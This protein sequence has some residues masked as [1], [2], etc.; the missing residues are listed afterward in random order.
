MSYVT[1]GRARIFVPEGKVMKKDEAFYNPAMR[2]QRDVTI[3]ALRVFSEMKGG[4]LSV[5]D[6][7]AGTG[8]RG[9]R[10]ALEVPGISGI[11]M[12]DM[13]PAA[14]RVL[15][16]NVDAVGLKVAKVE[17]KNCD[18][19][20]LLSSCDRTF[21]F[22]DIDPFGSPA[23]FLH[24]A[25]RALRHGSMLACTATDTGAL[26]GSF[27]KVCL[28]RY[29]V[30][31][32]KTDFYKET[33]VRVLTTAIM[34]EL[35]RRDLTFEPVYAHA[36]HYFR[37]IG[38]V[39]R[40]KSALTESFRKVKLISWCPRCIFRS[41]EVHGACPECGGRV[42]MLGPIWTGRLSDKDFCA[43]MAGE[44]KALGYRNTRELEAAAA[45]IEAPFYYDLH[46]LSK[47]ARKTPR[48]ADDVVSGLRAAGREA[49]RTRFCGTGVLTDASLSELL[50]LL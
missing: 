5:C 27:P 49:S 30:R 3:A 22:L 18:A 42:E 16:K 29:A 44:M 38:L 32:V 14:F 11:L 13:S 41:A 47:I 21:D 6:P 26:C 1:E 10:I 8:I 34:V 25:S 28:Q 23:G 4:G 35:A 33:G 45:E 24:A 46:R 36:N 7:L 43:K 40:K 17:M 19:D 48:K 39:R 9:I 37:V 50:R 2:Y 12:N 31:A 20:A 15:K